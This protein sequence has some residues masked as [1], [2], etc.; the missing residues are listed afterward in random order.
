MAEDIPGLKEAPPT[1][2]SF[3]RYLQQKGRDVSELKATLEKQKLKKKTKKIE[4]MTPTPK[5][6]L[7]KK[8]Q[9]KGLEPIKEKRKNGEAIRKQK[10]ARKTVIVKAMRPKSLSKMPLERR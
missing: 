1:Q 8:N 7:R 4:G 5:A 2:P 10:A 9:K 3:K 6:K